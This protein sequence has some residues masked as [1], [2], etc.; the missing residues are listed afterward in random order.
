MERRARRLRQEPVRELRVLTPP[1]VLGLPG[2]RGRRRR[3]LEGE[4]QEQREQR[5][6]GVRV[7]RLGRGKRLPAELHGRELARRSTGRG[8]ERAAPALES[9]R[10]RGP[11]PSAPGA[12]GWKESGSRSAAPSRRFPQPLGPSAPPHYALGSRCPVSLRGGR[13][14]AS[15]ARGPGIW[16]G[17]RGQGDEGSSGRSSPK[18][19]RPGWRHPAPPTQLGDLVSLPVGCCDFEGLRVSEQT[20]F[21]S[22]RLGAHFPED[23]NWKQV[24]KGAGRSRHCWGSL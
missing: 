6:G 19:E 9:I 21:S 1:G 4:Q 12:A 18:G 10:P 11:L 2:P 17:P 22:P 24:E 14:G 13:G 5:G 8:F 3:P 23:D 15:A 16:L 20:C 7:P